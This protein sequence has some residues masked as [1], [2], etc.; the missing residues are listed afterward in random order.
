[1]LATCTAR[2]GVVCGCQAHSPLQQLINP[3]SDEITGDQLQH[4]EGGLTVSLP[5]AQKGVEIC[6]GHHAHRRL[7]VLSSVDRAS[8]RRSK[9]G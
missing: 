3:D 7:G 1:M 8:A 4:P 6:S 5:S 2:G 9:V